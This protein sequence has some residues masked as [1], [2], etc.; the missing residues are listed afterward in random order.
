MSGRALQVVVVLLVFAFGATASGQARRLESYERVM[1][2]ERS[3]DRL[4]VSFLCPEVFSDWFRQRLSSGFTS[5]V[6][7]NL[8]LTDMR[9]KTLV[10]QGTIQYT[11][12]YD[13]WEERYAVRVEGLGIRQDLILRS[14][15][16]LVERLGAIRDLPLISLLEVS[17][18]SRY[19]L[20]ARIVINPTSPEMRRQ[21]REY[22]AHPDGRSA[23]GVQPSFF[24]RFSRIFVDEKKIQADA[25]L[26]YRSGPLSVPEPPGTD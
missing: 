20:Q 24:G 25:V 19:R 15:D 23:I 1:Q 3:A 12:R 16:D 14:M 11:I 8:Q 5:R 17:A 10:A 26:T 7:I 13:I 6:V 21:V 18:Q 2:V 22:V 4:T 9:G